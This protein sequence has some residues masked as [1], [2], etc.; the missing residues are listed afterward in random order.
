VAPPETLR[1]L[2]TEADEIICLDEP[3]DFGAVGQF[4][5][6]FRQTGDDEVIALLAAAE[7]IAP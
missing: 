5:R 6:D 3:E 2:Q 1:R 4:Y 7:K